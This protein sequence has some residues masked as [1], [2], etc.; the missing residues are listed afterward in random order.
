MVSAVHP[1]R[2]PASLGPAV[3]LAALLAGSAASGAQVSLVAAPSGADVGASPERMLLGQFSGVTLLDG[4]RTAPVEQVLAIFGQPRGVAVAPE[5]A[6][7][8]ATDLALAWAPAGDSGLRWASD[9]PLPVMAL[10]LGPDD[11]P[12]V[13]AGG[14]LVFLPEGLFG[15]RIRVPLPAVVAQASRVAVGPAGHVAVGSTANG[16]GFAVVMDPLGTPS[17]VVP[18]PEQGLEDARVQALG[19]DAQ[20]RFAVGTPSGLYVATALSPETAFVRLGAAD[21]LP[22]DSVTALAPWGEGGL[23]IGTGGG[24]ALWD[25]DLL[26][27]SVEVLTTEQGLVQDWIPALAADGAG[28]VL[29]TQSGAVAVIEED[30]GTPP[31]A[32]ADG[33]D[34]DIDGFVDT[35]D[36]GCTDSADLSENTPYLSCDDGADNDGDGLVDLADPDCG[37]RLLGREG[38]GC[39][40]GFEVALALPLFSVLCRRRGRR[41]RP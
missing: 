5:G 9:L 29:A 17:V 7:Y 38:E 41:G 26:A 21:G 25:G 12:V 22:R 2:R 30:A 32:C 10:A 8:V 13:V 1:V 27:P 37:G 33:I 23:A 36:L 31:P 6:L 39:G 24:L 11:A 20:G 40:G 34:N 35:E 3:L 28:R 15:P 18:G 16:G 19:V 4:W 14:S